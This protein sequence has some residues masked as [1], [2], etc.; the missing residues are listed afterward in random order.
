MANI[1]DR[2]KNNEEEVDAGVEKYLT[3]II[4]GRYY[5]YPIKDVKEIIEMQDITEVPEFP[6]YAKGIIN[7]R[8]IIIPVI[9]VRLRFHM[10]EHEYNEHTCIIVL[11]INETEIGFIVDTVDEV[12]DIEKS[13][14]SPPPLVRSEGHARYIEGVG[15]VSGKMIMLL[16]SSK[17]LNDD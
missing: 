2:F 12:L 9:D 17:M 14:I 7:L 8:D 3:F 1:Y 15:K 13:S 10:P 4:D 11:I 16:N 5:A 6:S